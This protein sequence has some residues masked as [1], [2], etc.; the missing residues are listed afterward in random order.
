MKNVI[1]LCIVLFLFIK[2]NLLS[3]NM[4]RLIEPEIGDVAN[5]LLID[6]LKSIILNDDDGWDSDPNLYE[7]AV[8]NLLY[9]YKQTETQFLLINLDTQIDN[10]K[11]GPYNLFQWQKY[12]VDNYAQGLLGDLSAFSAMDSIARFCPD[13]IYKM[14]A[15]KCLAEAGKFDYWNF[16]KNNKTK[17][18]GKVLYIMYGQDSRYVNEVKATLENELST[19]PPSNWIEVT[20]LVQNI[21]SI[22]SGYFSMKITEYFNNSTAKLRFNYFSQLGVWDKDGQPERS[23]FALQNEINDSFRV[24][25]IPTPNIVLSRSW[26]SKRY[27]EPK[28]VNFINN[29][30]ISDT[31]SATYQIR[32][33][34]LQTYVPATLDSTKPTNDLLDNLYNYVDSVMAYTWLADNTFANELKTKLITAKTDLQAGDSLAC[35]VQVKAFQDLVDNVYKDSL[36]TDARFVTIE[37][38]KFLYWNSQYILDR[39]PVDAYKKE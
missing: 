9:Y 35:R 20:S 8:K 31:N 1:I 16:V 32:K 17:L 10:S 15:I 26:I 29:L 3:Q 22:Q 24:E 34:F 28:F 33:Y 13:N 37:G 11:E 19:I 23:M 21:N 38:W 12:Y 6:S 7:S 27:L 18:M 14:M 39:L 25:Y 2:V 4:W 30:I 5:G 36:N